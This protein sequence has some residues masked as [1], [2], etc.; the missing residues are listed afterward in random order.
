MIGYFYELEYDV[1]EENVQEDGIHWSLKLLCIHIALYAIVNQDGISGLKE[2]A[3][4]KAIVRLGHQYWPNAG[5]YPSTI[6]CQLWARSLQVCR[7]AG[8]RPGPT[9]CRGIVRQIPPSK[10][11]AVLQ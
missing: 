7:R 8:H 1:S 10:I 6:S 4:Q 3:R 11:L 9:L 2:F 5:P